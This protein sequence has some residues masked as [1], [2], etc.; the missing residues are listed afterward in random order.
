MEQLNSHQLLEIEKDIVRE[1]AR[2]DFKRC[3]RKSAKLLKHMSVRWVD[4]KPYWLVLCDLQ[5]F[6][7]PSNLTHNVFF[8]F[9]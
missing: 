5:I 7:A 6:L 9:K 1:V 2:G 8:Y 3:L 4:P